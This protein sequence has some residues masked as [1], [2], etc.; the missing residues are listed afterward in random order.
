[1][2]TLYMF[3]TT[4]SQRKKIARAWREK[5]LTYLL[6]AALFHLKL[7]HL[8]VFTRGEYKMRVF[9]TPFAF[10]LW[11]E[12]ARERSDEFFYR[13]FL[14]EGDTVVDVGA[15]IGLCTLLSAHTVGVNGYVYSFEAHPRTFSHLKKNITLNKIKNVTAQHKGVSNKKETLFFTDEYVTDINHVDKEGSVQ[16]EMNTVDA[17]LPTELK[18]ITLLKIDVEG[19]ELFALQG[20]K[21]TLTR[22]KVVY[23]ES[24]TKSFERYGYTLLDIFVYLQSQG[25]SIYKP[26]DNL[27][28]LEEVQNEYQTMSG[29][30]NLIAVRKSDFMWLQERLS[31]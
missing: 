18:E 29:Y 24:A 3:Q 2:Y 15:N 20:A 21:E 22:T 27:S 12:H 23:F 31:H 17:L 6:Q 19:Y 4:K 16:V 13:Q 10:W 9:Y 5:N 11:S 25:F 26:N 14:R 28:I 8:C 30:E 7:S 1:M